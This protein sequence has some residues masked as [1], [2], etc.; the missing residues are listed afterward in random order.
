M[1]IAMSGSITARPPAAAW[2]KSRR[3]RGGAKEPIDAG[4]GDTE[5]AGDLRGANAIHCQ[6]AHLS[7]IN[8]LLPTLVDTSRLGLGDALTATRQT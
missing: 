7:H 3:G 6:P 1:S 8:T 5:A 4:T 2:R